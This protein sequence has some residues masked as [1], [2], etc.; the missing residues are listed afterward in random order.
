LITWFKT[1]VRRVRDEKEVVVERWYDQAHKGEERRP[2][3]FIHDW[4]KLHA[5]TETLTNVVTAARVTA[6]TGTGAG[7]SPHFI[8]LL[9]T[10]SQR[11]TVREVSGDKGY[12]DED[13]LTAVAAVGAL[14]FVAFKINVSVRGRTHGRSR[15]RRRSSPVLCTADA[16]SGSRRSPSSSEAS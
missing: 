16:S 6:G 12:L 1:S 10:T 15:G 5:M 9:H 2:R 14:P 3:R 8:P 11:F 7:D 13:N 4:L